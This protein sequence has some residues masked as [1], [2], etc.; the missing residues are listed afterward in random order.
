[1]HT[2]GFIRLAAVSPQVRL[3]DPLGNAREIVRLARQ[4]EE[5]AVSVAVFPELSLSGY[6]CG[7]LFFSRQL[8]DSA[9]EALA[10]VA[11]Q[12]GDLGCALIVGLPLLIRN[13]LYN[14]AALLQRGRV[15]GIVPKIHLPNSGEFNETR[16]FC[17]GR[18][19]ASR[20]ESILLNGVRIPFGHLL[21]RD[22]QSGF[23]FGIEICH[24][25]WM[26]VT[27]GA[28][29]VMAGALAL[30]NP[31]ASTDFAGKSAVRT[32]LVK[33]LSSRY[34]CAYVYAS[35]GP[36]ESTA[37]TVFS[38]QCILAEN[39]E[40]LKQTA[41]LNRGSAM[42]LADVDF[43]TIR[44]RRA[45]EQNFDSGLDLCAAPPVCQTIPLEELR[46][47]T[48]SDDLLSPPSRTPF[49]P[50][51]PEEA[52]AYCREIFALQ[53]TA[54]AER[55]QRA[56]VSTA[57]IGVSGGSDS[58]LA[59][60]AAGKAMEMNGQ[61]SSNV[62]AVTMPGL[63]TTDRT[64]D[65]A[66]RLMQA[67]GCQV[68]RISIV[69]SVLQHFKDIGQDPRN[70]DVTYE[71]AQAR[72][73]TQILMDLANQVGGLVVGTGDLSEMALGW[74]TYNGDHMSMY[75][76]NAGIPK[77]LVR[78][79]IATLAG[80]LGKDPGVLPVPGDARVLRETLEAVLDTPI[81]PEL[82]PPDAEGNILQQTEDQV[83]PYELHDFFLHHGI[84]NGARPER[85]LWLA[86]QAFRGTYELSEIRK[87]LAVFIRRFFSQQFKRNC[88]PDGPKLISMGL[89]PRVDWRMPS[90]ALADSWLRWLQ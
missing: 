49:V 83:G 29:L 46:C 54:L 51:A 14:C 75:G 26:P 10:L 44:T 70:T 79:V 82:L 32:N 28:R 19:L 47:L 40:V 61:P 16:W 81:S 48:L 17:S 58:T 23:S 1:M 21:F 18:G 22:E 24:D 11:E 84:Q 71:N 80:D 63:G 45:Q 8:Q 6:S 34:Q 39:G 52:D 50:E 68:R 67:L 27:P 73:R 90:D 85:V 5:Q 69:D 42:L 41:G 30:F 36:S 60:L 13:N 35:A 9:L 2:M 57:V 65:N 62:L 38:G 3:A 53:A 37:D 86:E 33:D 43:E 7:D 20:E 76:I 77:G 64:L 78:R 4:A 72:E 88:S 66:E 74:C 25:A 89:S 87:W 56:R 12:T 15:L 59:L 31:S 55:L